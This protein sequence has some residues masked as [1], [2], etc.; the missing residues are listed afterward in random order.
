MI[1]KTL[2]IIFY[3]FTINKFFAQNRYIERYV[4]E[5]NIA[6]IIELNL[7]ISN[8]NENK[9]QYKLIIKKNTSDKSDSINKKNS[10]N[11]INLDQLNI[12]LYSTNGNLIYEKKLFDSYVSHEGIVFTC[13][14]DSV[15]FDCTYGRPYEEMDYYKRIYLNLN[16]LMSKDITLEQDNDYRIIRGGS[17]MVP[18]DFQDPDPVYHLKKYY[19]DWDKGKIMTGKKLLNK[20]SLDTLDNKSYRFLIVEKEKKYYNNVQKKYI[21]GK[22][23][24]E[25]KKIKISEYDKNSFEKSNQY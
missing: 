11:V 22:E 24:I 18:V 13:H 4:D 2:I 19:L 10:I 9:N 21:S 14:S 6:P 17:W 23:L 16:T 1:K 7:Q 5:L 15:Y 8:Y 12:K 20:Y 3:L 25:S